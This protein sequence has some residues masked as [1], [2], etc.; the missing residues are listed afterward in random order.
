MTGFMVQGQICI[1]TKR[2]INVKVKKVKCVKRN[3]SF[4]EYQNSAN[5]SKKYMQNK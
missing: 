3:H 5:R 2:I 4:S 1:P